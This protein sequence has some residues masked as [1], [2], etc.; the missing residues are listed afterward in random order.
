MKSEY[1]NIIA[2][3]LTKEELSGEEKEILETLKKD[4]ETYKIIVQST[5][6]IDKAENYFDLKKF[7]A[8]KA[9]SKLDHQLSSNKKK[10][11]L[12]WIYRAAAI[13]LLLITT[14]IAIWQFT[15][16]KQSYQEFAS[17][18]FDLSKP[19][20]ILP[21][22]TKVTLNHN[23]KITFPDE[24]SGNTREITLSGEAFF[25]V[26]PNPEK[27]F[28]INTKSASIR[29][30]GT[31]FNVYAYNNVPTVEVMVKTG[32]VELFDNQTVDH[33]INNKVLLLPGEK[34]VL[35]K[36][37]GKIIK[38]GTFNHN[39]LSWITQE[40]KFDYSTL[41]DVVSTLQRTF[42]LQIEVDPNVDQNLQ[43][44]ATF[45]RQK[46]D[47]IMNVVAMTFNLKYEKTGNN[48]F[49]IVNNN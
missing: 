18:E 17:S 25:E 12:S 43:L 10:I 36:H 22:G 46:P 21:D 44:S 3:Y 30:L 7:D 24:F 15:D 5:E 29:V 20:I 14:G 2:K 11:S 33:A 35:N 47:Y 6:V 9:W 37:D 42:N 19:E 13:M 40:I 23:S 16:K 28:I 32:K 8:D 31:S 27:P 48:S 1:W 34:G 39:N 45:T 4:E 49:R 26:N 38:E 41:R